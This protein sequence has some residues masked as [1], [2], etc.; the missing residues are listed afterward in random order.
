MP[1]HSPETILSQI[2]RL[3]LVA[4]MRRERFDR[5]EVKQRAEREGHVAPM[6]RSPCRRRRAAPAGPCRHAR[7][8]AV[9]PFQPPSRPLPVGLAP[10]GRRRDHAVREPRALQVAGAVQ[11]REHALGEL[12]GLFERRGGD[13]VGEVGVEAALEPRGEAGRVI[14]GEEHVGDG[15]AVGHRRS[16]GVPRVLGARRVDLRSGKPETGAMYGFVHGFNR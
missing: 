16:S 15:R 8:C 11:R 3:Q 13:A 1:V 2:E 14:H 4:G 6:S 10:A 9:T 12:R 7:R 5:A